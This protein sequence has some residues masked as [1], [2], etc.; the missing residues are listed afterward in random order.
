MCCAVFC[1]KYV[2]Y[3]GYTLQCVRVACRECLAADAT[4]FGRTEAGLHHGVRTLLPCGLPGSRL[5]P[6]TASRVRTSVPDGSGG[7]TLHSV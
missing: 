2:S 1:E 4:S 5:L 6:R 7:G 3:G